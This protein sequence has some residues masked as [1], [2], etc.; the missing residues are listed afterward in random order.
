MLFL[1]MVTF[2]LKLQLQCI[3]WRDTIQPIGAPVLVCKYIHLPFPKFF[4]IGSNT[5]QFSSVQ[6]LSRVRL[7]ATPWNTACQASLSI[8]N[9]QSLLKHIPLSQ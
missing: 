9:Y 5:Y 3:S 8:A 4:V 7:F 2:L 6:L 1:N